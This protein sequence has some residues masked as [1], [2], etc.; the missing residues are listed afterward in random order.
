MLP[1]LRPKQDV[2]VLC[3]FFKIKVGDLVAFKK[4]GKEMIKRI[5][6]ITSDRNIF[7]QGD[8]RAEST[9]SR[10]FGLIKK[11]HIIGKVIWY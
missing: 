7:V 5:G 2:L 6:Q 8:N 1:T 9:D 11:S 4:D 3:W 10:K